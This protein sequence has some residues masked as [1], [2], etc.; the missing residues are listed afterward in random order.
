MAF[1]RLIF[2]ETPSE[3][4]AYFSD[5]RRPGDL[6]VPLSPETRVAA[7]RR[8]AEWQDTTAFFSPEAHE[9][10]LMRAHLLTLVAGRE[11]GYQDRFG[12]SE[13]YLDLLAV[14]LRLFHNYLFWLSEVV[15]NA[16]AAHAGCAVAA[17]AAGPASAPGRRVGPEE[18]YAG[19]LARD[20][21]LGSGREFHGLEHRP[22][23]G[24][25]VPASPAASGPAGRWLRR[26]A[27]AIY[28][29]RLAGLAGR[30]PLVMAS[31][32]YRMD[33]LA[34]RAGRPP[35]TGRWLTLAHTRPTAGAWRAL[36]AALA[37]TPGGK[38][39][40]EE[41][42]AAQANLGMFHD[43]SPP[44]AEG[45]ERACGRLKKGLAAHPELSANRAVAYGGHISR[46]I[47]RALLPLLLRE[48]PLAWG[49]FQALSRLR[50]AL[51][52][53][54]LSRELSRA[55]CE[56]GRRLGVPTLMISHG[57][58]TPMAG[59]LDR[60]AWSFQSEG[61]L[62]SATDYSVLQSPLAEEHVREVPTRTTFFRTEPLAW[63]C[64]VDRQAGRRLRREWFGEEESNLRV[65]VHA[66]SPKFR[67]GLHLYAFETVDEY[68]RALKDMIA[69]TAR[70]PRTRLVIRIRP[71]PELTTRDLR[72]L[73]PAGDHVVFSDQGP[74]L[75]VLGAADLLVSFCSTTME[76]ALQNR[77]PVVF[78][79][80][81]SRYRHIRGARVPDGS[82]DAPR[83]VYQVDEPQRLAEGLE[84]ALALQEGRRPVA[85][86]FARY[87]WGPE[88]V[89]PI[90]EVVRRCTEQ[91]APLR[92]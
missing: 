26:L 62:H 60:M 65:V 79:G 50:P 45:L 82:L 88:Q 80:V 55:P 61:L 86:D 30:R 58:F 15:Q 48:Q 36:G 4:A 89:R 59:R 37:R 8:R 90:A 52:A 38:R 53:S 41:V 56:A 42:F 14:N 72:E 28:A 75:E 46:R 91:G 20:H 63:G 76:E 21:C 23:A 68:L 27:R 17:F 7:V 66:G 81:G 31:R 84:Q 24:E 92:R 64:Q 34:R 2:L 35:G 12:L 3:A 51:L 39:P 83:A 70:L 29:R 25:P 85:G 32:G 87:S 1:Q 6:V 73:L 16:A 33:Q 5:H 78:Y 74:F 44:D 43:G 54:P 57:S 18:G 13:T 67:A 77:V 9:R 11:F 22:P 10:G 19:L 69:A 47:D 49:C 40:P 71:R